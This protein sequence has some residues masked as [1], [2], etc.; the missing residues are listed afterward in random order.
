MVQVHVKETSWGFESPLRHFSLILHPLFQAAEAGEGTSLLIV[1]HPDLVQN[2]FQNPDRVIIRCLI[3]RI[4]MTVFPPVSET[5][6]NGIT[7][8]GPRAV[9]QFG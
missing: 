2:L 8:A 6:T 4:R 7:G 5:E 3:H 9:D 1:I